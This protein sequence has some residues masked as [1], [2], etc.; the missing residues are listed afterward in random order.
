MWAPHGFPWIQD[1]PQA[2][3]AAT[4]PEAL[5]ALLEVR[6]FFLATGSRTQELDESERSG[7]CH[8]TD[9]TVARLSAVGEALLRSDGTVQLDESAGNRSLVNL[10]WLTPELQARAALP[11]LFPHAGMHGHERR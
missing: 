3:S 7:L 4:A 8:L 10:A 9:R 1:V 6:H 5:H 2:A 11:D